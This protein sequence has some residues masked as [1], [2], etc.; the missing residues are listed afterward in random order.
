MIEVPQGNFGYG[1]ANGG[2]GGFDDGG[3]DAGGDKGEGSGHLA[4][5]L[6]TLMEQGDY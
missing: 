2:S 3:V 5:V 1:F 4:D 6:G